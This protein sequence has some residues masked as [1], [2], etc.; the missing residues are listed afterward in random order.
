MPSTL[1]QRTIR[2]AA[3]RPE[4]RK[5]LLPLLGRAK[6]PLRKQAMRKREILR[7]VSM[8]SNDY[9]DTGHE[10]LVRFKTERDANRFEDRVNSGLDEEYDWD[11]MASGSLDSRTGLYTIAVPIT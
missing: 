7:M 11:E 6:R 8:A 3:Q 10:I 2:L 5:H 1:R 4:L 9:E